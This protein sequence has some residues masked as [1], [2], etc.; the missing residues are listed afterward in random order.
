[1]S[2]SN[3]PL[4][5]SIGLSG[6][7]RWLLVVGAVIAVAAAYTAGQRT[8]AIAGGAFLVIALAALLKTRQP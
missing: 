6:V 2:E 8:L 3:S 1:M 4:T 7:I 5:R